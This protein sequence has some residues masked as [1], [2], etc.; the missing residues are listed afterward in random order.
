[1]STKYILP[2]I[3]ITRSFQNPAAPCADY[4]SPKVSTTL[5]M[6]APLCNLFYNG[7][8]TPY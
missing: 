8:V 1:M 3:L 2:S 7:G 4:S 6:Y 5:H